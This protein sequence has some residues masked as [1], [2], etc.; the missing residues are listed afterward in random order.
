MAFKVDEDAN[1]SLI[2]GDS[3][4]FTVTGIPDDKNY[5]VYFAV[6]DM[7]RKP[8]G[9]ELSVS[10]NYSPSVIFYLT[11]DYTNLFKVDKDESFAVY[12]YGV[13]ICDSAGNIE[14]T[15]TFGSGSIDSVNTITVY[16]KKVEGA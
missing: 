13:K 12:Y 10:S 5:T 3:G 11:G 15:L 9:S 7:N 1:I 16:P 6:R 2:Q 14:D 4:T 8:V